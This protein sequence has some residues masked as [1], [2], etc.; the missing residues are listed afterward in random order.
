MVVNIYAS[1]GELT[2]SWIKSGKQ[3]IKLKLIELDSL[4]IEMQSNDEFLTAAGMFSDH[5][6]LLKIRL[7]PDV[8]IEFA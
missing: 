2:V 6:V 5:A 3:L 1:S 7:K 4:N 8:A